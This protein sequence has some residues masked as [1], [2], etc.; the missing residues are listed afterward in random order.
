MERLFCLLA[1]LACC[2]FLYLPFL[3]L[4]IGIGL[5]ARIAGVASIV[6]GGI[7]R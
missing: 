7:W 6:L 1:E 5:F 3:G 2:C 4:W